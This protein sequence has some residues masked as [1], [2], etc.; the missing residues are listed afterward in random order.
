MLNTN[1]T[2]CPSNKCYLI[3]QDLELSKNIITESYIL[4][5]NL[6]IGRD[7]SKGDM[8][9]SESLTDGTGNT[10]LYMDG[11]IGLS[12]G[13]D[14]EIFSDISYDIS[15]KGTKL[16]FPNNLPVLQ[17][18]ANKISGIEAWFN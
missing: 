7:T 3:F 14:R 1:S 15:A 5:G 4:E 10:V 12:E 6:K 18:K 16:S 2:L 11:Q 17:L 13:S 9:I 8:E